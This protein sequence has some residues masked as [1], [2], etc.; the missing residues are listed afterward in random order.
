MWLLLALLL[1]F[2]AVRGTRTRRGKGH[3]YADKTP[4]AAMVTPPRE[5]VS[6]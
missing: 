4:L 6:V 5:K 1:G 2:T 3:P